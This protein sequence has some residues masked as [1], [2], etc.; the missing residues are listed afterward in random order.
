MS[1]IDLSDIASDNLVQ[2][3][4][5]ETLDLRGQMVRMGSVVDQILHR[6]NYPYPVARLL[7]EALTLTSCLANSLKFEGVFTLQIQSDGPVSLL[8][9]DV[10]DAGALRGY[11][12]FNKEA[13]NDIRTDQSIERGQ[14][15]KIRDVLGQGHLA[16]TM[17]SKLN[18]DRYQGIIELIGETLTDCVHHYFHQ[19]EQIETVIKVATDHL[20]GT[21][22]LAGWRS[23]ALMLQR[24]P[25]E[26][27]SIEDP[28]V[29]EDDWRRALM[30][31]SS[32]T[33]AE[34]LDPHLSARD[35]IY[36]LFN[37]DGVRVFDTLTL[38]DECHCADGRMEKVLQSLSPESLQ[39]MTVDG[40]VTVTCQFCKNE[41]I[42]D[43]AALEALK[44]ES[45]ET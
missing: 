16:F 21:E 5:I 10:T 2:P 29:R 13:L 4:Q 33:A 7:A 18:R 35:L 12:Q 24:L 25:P 9:C 23:C 3:F 8:V 19:S 39:D 20:E 1:S 11:A 34:M 14:P 44:S 43:E 36:R 22:D 45:E 31:L 27:S 15:M 37:E 41:K 17:D 26:E 38:K 42:F 28:E 6:H 40:K 30:F 32:S